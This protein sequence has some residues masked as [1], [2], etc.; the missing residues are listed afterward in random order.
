MKYHGMNCGKNRSLILFDTQ[1]YFL[2]IEGKKR[3]D[4]NKRN[5]IICNKRTKEIRS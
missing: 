5:Y 2:K 1:I 4:K 3:K